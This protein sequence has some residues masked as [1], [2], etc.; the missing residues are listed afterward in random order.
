MKK[1]FGEGKKKTVKAAELRR[2]EQGEKMI[3]EFIQKFR[4]AV[5]RSKYER[6]YLIKKFKQSMNGIV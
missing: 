4:K 6:R 5:R 2:I 3:E 1:E